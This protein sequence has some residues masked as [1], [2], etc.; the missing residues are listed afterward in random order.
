[1]AVNHNC[2]AQ[3]EM[4]NLKAGKFSPIKIWIFV[5]YVNIPV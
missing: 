1:M 5:Q 2:L 3:F 4:Q